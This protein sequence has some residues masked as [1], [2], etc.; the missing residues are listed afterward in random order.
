MQ[1]DLLFHEFVNTSEA[2]LINTMP[3]DAL[4]P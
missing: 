2:Y 4:A 3:A 1:F